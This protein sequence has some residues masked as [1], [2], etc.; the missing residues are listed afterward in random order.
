MPLI[1]AY[2]L[3]LMRDMFDCLFAMQIH[4]VDW[5]VW[6]LLSILLSPKNTTK[7]TKTNKRKT[8]EKT[9]VVKYFMLCVIHETQD[10]YKPIQLIDMILFTINKTTFLDKYLMV[11]I[12]LICNSRFLFDAQ[13]VEIC[14]AQ[15][16]LPNPVVS[17]VPVETLLTCCC[18]L[19]F[20]SMA[21]RQ[22]E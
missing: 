9:M 11:R 3:I 12:C 17:F 21:I 7:N 19:K 20:T 2:R 10:I 14:I 6:H 4:S 16:P 8:I 1:C 18:W 13:N 15:M 5:F 22:D